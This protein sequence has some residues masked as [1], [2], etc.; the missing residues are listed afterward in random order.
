VPDRVQEEADRLYG[1]PLEEF[2]RSPDEVAKALRREKERD[3]AAE[4]ARLPK[5]SAGA[6]AVNALAREQPELRDELLAAGEALRG[7]Q[8]AALAGEGR[9]ALRDA[10]ARERAAVDAM[11]AAASKLRPGGRELSTAARDALRQTL[12]AAAVDDDVRAAIAAGRLVRDAV[13]GGAWA[14]G[15]GS[16]SGDDDEPVTPVRRERPAPKASPKVAKPRAKRA[17]KPGG[18][19]PGA[20]KPRAADDAARRERLE[21]ERAADAARREAER[22]AAK[23]RRALERQL[24]TARADRE[25]AAKS[26]AAAERE[27]ERAS[28]RRDAAAEALAE[29]R[30]AVARLEEQCD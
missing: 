3:A 2:T 29:A 1:L 8:D 6:W 14:F 19:K 16:G 24:T 9:S 30:D 5:P 20:T 12:H 27:L 22:A 4:V 10:T 25:R 15:S 23:A 28:V 21:A 18:A 26:L 17:A 11:I 13:G 7:A